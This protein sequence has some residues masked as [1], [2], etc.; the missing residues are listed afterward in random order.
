MSLAAACTTPRS[1]EDADAGT[2]LADTSTS[3][4]DASSTG[5]DLST[6]SSGASDSSSGQDSSTGPAP[7]STGPAPACGDGQQDPGEDC[8]DGNDQDDDA[9]VAD[10]LLAACGDGHV[11]VGHEACDDG[12]DLDDDACSN[13]CTLASCGDGEVQPGETCDDGNAS[14]QDACPGTCQAAACGDGFVQLGVEA[15]DDEVASAQC[16]ADCSLPECGDKLVNSAAAE[17]CDDGEETATCD[18]DCSLPEC[19]DGTLSLLAGEECD[20]GNLSDLDDCSSEC[21]KL[22]RTIFVTSKL[23]TGKLGGIVGADKLCQQLAEDAGLPGIF[24]AWLSDSTTTPAARF[25]KSSVPYVLSSGIQVAKNWQDLSDGTLQHSI[26]TTETKG[27]A[28]IAAVGCGGGTKPTVWTN[29]L[30]AGTAWAVNG[31]DDWNATTGVARLGH[32]KATNFTWAKFCEG[33]AASCAWKA[34]LYCVEQ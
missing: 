32:A 24:Y 15:C 10:C 20:D 29:T 22:R 8:D 4:G 21:K 26:D 27:A 9:C 28:P 23:Y 25:V 34:A 3:T 33:Q 13:D 2:S 5:P 17:A 11:H 19:G 7:G 18:A 30:A 6:S 16:D 14:N 1:N 31:C 12:N